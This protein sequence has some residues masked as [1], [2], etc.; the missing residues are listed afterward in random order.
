MRPHR[1]RD[2]GLRVVAPGARERRFE[3]LAAVD[4]DHLHLQAEPARAGF[5]LAQHVAGVDDFDRIDQD[6]DPPQRR[7]R[8]LEQLEPLRAEL[9]ET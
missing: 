1:D 5:G 9:G 7:H 8:L 2:D 4:L 6:G 3:V